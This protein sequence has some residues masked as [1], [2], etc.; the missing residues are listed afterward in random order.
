MYANNRNDEKK[1]SVMDHGSWIM[2]NGSWITDKKK[3]TYLT[4]PIRNKN[5]QQTNKQKRIPTFPNV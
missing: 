5:T 2:D 4:S 1:K 3:L